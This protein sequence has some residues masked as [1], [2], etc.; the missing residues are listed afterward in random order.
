MSDIYPALTESQLNSLPSAAEAK[1]YRALRDAALPNVLIL[2][3]RS[4][5]S[6]AKGGGHTDREADFVIADER[7]GILAIEVKG[8]GVRIDP[9]KGWVS[10][11]RNGQ[12][13]SIKDPFQQAKNEKYAILNQLE[14][15]PP[16]SRFARR[17]TLAHAV[18]FPD[19]RISSLLQSADFLKDIAG[20]KSEISDIEGWVKEIF[21]YWRRENDRSLD[22]EGLEIIRQFYCSQILAKPLLKDVL[23]EQDQLRIKLT[24][25]QSLVLRTLGRHK[26]AGIVGAAGT[27][28]TILAVE[29]ARSLVES[30]CRV[31][32]LC[33][34]R[35]LGVALA[36]RFEQ[37]ENIVV[38][39][40]HQFCS[41]CCTIAKSCKGI[42]AESQ[43]KIAEPN[44]DLFDVQFPLAACMAIEAVGEKLQF[45]A[46]IVDE[47]QDFGDE[48]WLPIEL[49]LKS[50]KESWL[51]IFYDENQRLYK[52]S[53]SFPID[54]SDIFP[55]SRNCRNTV[56]IHNLAYRFYVGDPIV[57]SGL[58]G[59]EP[60]YLEAASF[61]QQ[62]RLVAQLVV[63]L[64]DKE[65]VQPK[66]IAVLIGATNKKLYYWALTSKPIPSPAQWSEEEH[67]NPNGIVVDTIK[68]F[69]GM[70]RDVII[71]WINE[72]TVQDDA[73]LYVGVSRA[74][75]ALFVVGNAENIVA[76]KFV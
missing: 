21:E 70:E 22:K 55:L 4:I 30:G 62:A 61:E 6:P 46:V 35:P 64:L 40:F 7:Y 67:F 47:G 76:L 48:Y 18:L 20:G 74:K 15:F 12:E 63:A 1:V 36:K 71:L 75:S 34:N 65:K 29:K 58:T 13:N 23:E 44:Q 25:E 26:R 43:A 3:G 59:G 5:V 28:K 39:S 53:S 8:G 49:A 33:Y 57:H 42:D 51:Y 37:T 19:I 2:H 9:K 14:T 69:K 45:D 11:D 27:G 16:W 66:D 52:R 32:L 56:P 50:S 41:W 54:G 73:L 68:R 60:D 72:E 17:I 31:L 10:V 38:M 24:Q